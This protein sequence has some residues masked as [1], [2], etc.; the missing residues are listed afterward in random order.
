MSHARSQEQ[1]AGTLWW[2]VALIVEFHILL[3]I[4]GLFAIA[5]AVL[6][7]LFLPNFLPEA[8]PFIWLA[9]TGLVLMMIGNELDEE[10]SREFSEMMEQL[11][12]LASSDRPGSSREIWIYAATLFVL[13]VF[14]VSTEVT[15]VAAAAALLSMNT[16]LGVVAIAGAL[17]Y[18]MFDAWLGK[19]LGLNVASIGLLV[20]IGLMDLIAL[21]YRVPLSVPHEAASQ[22]RKTVGG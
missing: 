22:F 12:E 2:A 8:E 9:I 13:F 10:R 6:A 14:M 17:L 21:F 16:S 1:L 5:G 20:G 19:T 15:V 3:V 18:P 4:W 7:F 11:L